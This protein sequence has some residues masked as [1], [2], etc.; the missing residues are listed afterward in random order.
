MTLPSRILKTKRKI[1]HQLNLNSLRVRLTVG[2]TTVSAIGLGSVTIWTTLKMQHILITTHKEDIQYIAERLP[3]DIEIYSQM[4]SSTAA[5][6]KA[7]DYRT[8]ANTVLWVQ[9]PDRS[10]IVQSSIFKSPDNTSFLKSL[11]SVPPEPRVLEVEGRYWVLCGTNLQLDGETLGKLYVAKDVTRD[12]KMFLD[13]IPR[14]SIVSLLSIAAIT[15]L[16]ALHV[17][18]SLQPLQK[19][20]Q[21]TKKIDAESLG[22]ATIHLD[23]APSEVRELAQTFDEMLLRLHESWEQQRQFVSNVSHELRT[24]LTIV[25]GYLQSTLR[26]GS[27]LTEPQREALEI[28]SSETARTIS[29]LQTLLDLARADS[30]HLHLNLDTFLLNDLVKEIVEMAKQYSN[31]IINFETNQEHIL[32][33]ADASRLKQVLLNLIDN[34]VKYSDSDQAITVKLASSKSQAIVQVC[35]RGNGIPLQHQ[36]RIFERFYRLDEARSHSTGGT[37]LGLSIVKTLV[38]EM[39]GSVSV[40]SQ[41]SKGSI[42]TVILPGEIY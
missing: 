9:R 8:D 33:K 22:E 38:E 6:Q 36:T 25:S 41:L 26:R 4:M 28:A 29:L 18:R 1:W 39:G 35:D 21:L 34:A 2:I 5:M 20:S 14:L 37:G 42:F 16:I 11:S 15:I 40:R 23:N 7:I 10:I 24:P 27:N 13:M 3:Q 32:V 12:L 31:R 19:M 30:G 17:R